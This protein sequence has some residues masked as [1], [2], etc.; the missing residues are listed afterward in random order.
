[1]KKFITLV[2]LSTFILS[3]NASAQIPSNELGICLADNLNGKER[4][5]L[6]KWIFFSMAA[7]P[8][9]SSYANVSQEDST[10][11]NKF[12]GNLI[13]RLLT[14][15]CKDIV[16]K[17]AKNDPT[18]IQLAFTLVGEVAMQELTTDI[19]VQRSIAEYINYTDI[20]KIQELLVPVK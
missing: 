7:H 10:N 20:N 16:S 15:D 13:T 5:A 17:I 9:I 4:K 8:E 1:M 2:F 3:F 12:I 11:S 6:A 14:S 19:N 18:S